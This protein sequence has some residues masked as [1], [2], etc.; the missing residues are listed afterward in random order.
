MENI[1][2]A[3]FKSKILWPINIIRRFPCDTLPGL[4]V[5]HVGLCLGV[6][7]IRR[8]WQII[9]MRVI[10]FK[11]N[12]EKYQFTYFLLQFHTDGISLF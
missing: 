7:E 9:A 10:H 8:K 11:V 12:K 4:R 6:S 3:T 2:A 1:Y 5:C